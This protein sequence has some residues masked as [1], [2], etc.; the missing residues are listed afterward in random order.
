M[1]EWKSI[2]GYSRYEAS[3]M[4]NIRTL[5]WK[6]TNMVKVMKPSLDGSGYL[7][8]MLKRDKD[9]KIHTIKVHRIIG[10]TF[11][12]NLDNKPEINHLNGI[13]SDNRLINLEWCSHSENIKDSFTKKR[14]NNQGENGPTHKLTNEQVIEIRKN[15]V[16]GNNNAHKRPTLQ[17]IADKYNVCAGSIKQI[18]QKKTWT[19]LL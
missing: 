3:T 1:E 17:Q 8:T 2:P 12:L 6:N 16:G 11:I 19:H 7:R 4:G 13:R 15:Y 5:N 14:S 18:I 10:I 9:G